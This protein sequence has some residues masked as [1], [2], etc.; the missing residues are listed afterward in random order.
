[1]TSVGEKEEKANT[2]KPPF[3][4]FSH[5]HRGMK[6]TNIFNYYKEKEHRKN[7]CR[8][9]RHMPAQKA[10]GTVVVAEDGTYS[11]EDIVLV[12]D[13]HT[14]YTDVWVLDFRVSYLICPRREWFST[15]E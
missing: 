5:L 1:V 11:E 9:K 14:H 12:A 3:L 15:Y 2:I 13:S 8:K 7:D 4:C 10:S 6:P